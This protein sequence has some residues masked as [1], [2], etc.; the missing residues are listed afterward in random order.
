[1]TSDLPSYLLD[2]PAPA[3]TATAPATK[4]PGWFRRNLW[5]LLTVVPITA[6]LGVAMLDAGAAYDRIWLAEPRT[7]VAVVDGWAAY[8]EAKVRLVQLSEAKDLRE[9]ATR[10]FVLPQG[11]QAW[12][13]TIEFTVD[14]P[15]ALA[16]CKIW[17]ED[18]S[19]VVYSA[20]PE[21]LSRARTSFPGC[22]ADDETEKRF[23]TVAYFVTPAGVEPAAVRVTLRAA[24]PDF[25][26]LPTGN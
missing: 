5:G 23:Q 8:G 2:E 17:L 1:M 25:V 16:G 7:P 20:R 4:A 11:L 14:D 6:A 10:P 19:G 13:A 22:T 15:E 18:T 24:Y 3:A 26:R 21:E 9:S 12:Q